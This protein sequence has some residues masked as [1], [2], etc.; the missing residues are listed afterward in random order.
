MR[1]IV[2]NPTERSIAYQEVDKLTLE[3]MQA[4]VGGYIEFVYHEVRWMNDDFIVNEEGMINH[5]PSWALGEHIYFGNAI[6]VHN[7]LDTEGESHHSDPHVKIEGL[8]GMVQF[9]IKMQ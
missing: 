6:M 2:I 3:M 1:I 9:A 5:L 4:I 8:W 7:Q